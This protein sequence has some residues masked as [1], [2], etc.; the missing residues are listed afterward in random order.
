LA[1]TTAV[2]IVL[3]I[4]RLGHPFLTMLSTTALGLTVGFGLLEVGV[5]NRSLVLMWTA[6]FLLVAIMLLLLGLF[7]NLLVLPTARMD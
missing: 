7:L 6:A 4:V 1:L 3:A 2:A 5:R